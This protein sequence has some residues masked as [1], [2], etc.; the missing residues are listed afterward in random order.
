MANRVSI[1]VRHV[2][3]ENCDELL[4]RVVTCHYLFELQI[5]RAELDFSACD[6]QEAMFSDRWMTGVPTCVFEEVLLRVKGSDKNV[7]ATFGLRRQHPSDGL[8]VFGGT[9]NS[10]LQCFEEERDHGI[11]PHFH[12]LVLVEM[13]HHDPASFRLLQTSSRDQN[14]EMSI[15]IQMPAETVRHYDEQHPNTVLSFYPLLN[16]RGSQCG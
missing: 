13:R 9:D 11:T 16:R 4:D 10:Q 7:P 8:L 5:L 14:V 12:Q 2:L 3:G 6:L 1:V 15:E